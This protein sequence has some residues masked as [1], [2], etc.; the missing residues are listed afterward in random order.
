MRTILRLIL[1]CLLAAF[2]G[3]AA[4]AQGTPPTDMVTLQGVLTTSAG[5]PLPDGQYQATVAVFDSVAGGRQLGNTLPLIFDQVHGAFTSML[6]A[7]LFPVDNVRGPL[8]IEIT[9]PQVSQEPLAPRMHIGS[10]PLALHARSAVGQAPVGAVQ[11]YAGADSTLPATW[12]VCDGRAL[13]LA[14]YQALYA[15]IGTQWGNEDADGDGN[16]DFNIPDMRGMLVRGSGVRSIETNHI[17]PASGSIQGNDD[18]LVQDL[19]FV[20]MHYIIRVR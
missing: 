9:I 20:S 5:V 12:M 7:D 14:Q 2:I 16:A 18:A 15:A 3:H 13:P 19:P 8:F 1:T 11:M 4:R 10:V 17:L 6:P